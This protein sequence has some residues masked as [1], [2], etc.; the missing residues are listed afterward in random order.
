MKTLII[1]GSPR[2][3]GDTA[4][5]INILKQELTGDIVEISA[6]RNNIKPCNDCRSCWKVKGCATF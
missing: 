4:S 5:L 6:Y 1:N 2:K 3:K